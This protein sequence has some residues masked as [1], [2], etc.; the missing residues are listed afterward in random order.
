MTRKTKNFHFKQFSIIGGHA[1][2]AVSTDGVLLGAW[3]DFADAERLL[4]IGTGTGLLALMCAQRFESLSVDAIDIDQQAFEASS[5]N[6]ANSPWSAR[7]K[8]FHQ[9]LAQYSHA[10]YDAIIC[11][12]P[13][14]NSG[15][16]AQNQQRATARHTGS[17]SHGELA[18]HIARLLTPQIGRACLIL[19]KT[20]GEQFID[21]ARKSGLQLTRLCRVR[22]TAAKPVSRL[23]IELNNDQQLA[24][25]QR[26]GTAHCQE[27]EITIHKNGR[28][29]DD[30][31][32]LTREF[33]LKM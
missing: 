5:D 20:E 9:P 2:M 33:Y 14:F 10:C 15:E 12:P 21:L 3:A 1:G 16:S 13:Y 31:I 4:D 7:I 18:E 19:P 26:L 24:N 22:P 6:I 27:D 23:L 25:E 28:Y 29:S 30:F 11:N 17:L 32:A 8:V